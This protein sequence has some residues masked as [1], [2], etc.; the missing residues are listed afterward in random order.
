M[1]KNKEPLNFENSTDFSL[2]SMIR[3]NA[4]DSSSY[5]SEDYTIE[6][7]IGNSSISFCSSLNSNTNL[8]YLNSNFKIRNKSFS[9]VK[10]ANETSL[11]QINNDCLN[12][13]DN[14]E[15]SICHDRQDDQFKEN[16]IKVIKDYPKKKILLKDSSCSFLSNLT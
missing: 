4:S 10:E 9:V 7:L 11:M 15:T 14:I 12:S 16:L 8:N 3:N 2:S 5:F 6:G 13:E 1:S